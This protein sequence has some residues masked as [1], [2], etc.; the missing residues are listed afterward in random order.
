MSSQPQARQTD[1]NDGSTLNSAA[2]G[3]T[4]DRWLQEDVEDGPYN[5]IDL[6]P[7]EPVTA[8]DSHLPVEDIPSPLG[9]PTPD[10]TDH[11]NE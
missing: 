10:A 4:L 9:Y 11:N 8:Q 6:V 2:G 1:T 5:A 3:T 7:S